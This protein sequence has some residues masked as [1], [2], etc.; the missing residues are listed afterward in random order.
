[1][2]IHFLCFISLVGC[3]IYNEEVNIPTQDFDTIIPLNVET[4][5]K[6]F[7]LEIDPIE[8]DSMYS[9]FNEEIEIEASLNLIKN[10]DFLIKN[11]K[12][13]IQVKGSFSSSFDLKSLGIKFD[14]VFDNS[15]RELIDVEVLPFHTIDKIKSFRLRNSG[16][17][18][19]LTMLKDMSL[20]KLALY[21]KLDVDVMYSEQAVVFINDTFLGIMNIR[22]E[23]N[24]HG[25][26]RL[27]GAKKENVTLVNIKARG[28][29][30]K[31]D[32]DFERI[33]RLFEAIENSEID[34]LLDEIDIP[35]F[36][37][38]II[39]ETYIGNIDWPL[40]NVRIFAIDEEPFR[41]VLF[42][43]DMAAVQ[44]TNAPPLSFLSEPINN[45]GVNYIST[46]FDLLYE[47]EDFK[48]DF[49]SR[50]EE[51]VSSSIL[52]SSSFE[53]I[54][55]SYKDNI[56]HIMPTQIDR[57]SFP[58]SLTEWIIEVDRLKYNF[59]KRELSAKRFIDSD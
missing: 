3:S 24:G 48:T 33:D 30:E 53:L 6:V 12:V 58:K 21:A 20:V 55:D 35:N 19:K 34:L 1:M 17:D 18:F 43:L 32:G 49:N 42:D 13:E 38:Y 10:G 37:D 9:N 11:E 16:N 26:S 45:D 2:G 29:V 46:L 22:T 8:F 50:F 25:L 23:T 57:Y 40:N 14:K 51:I 4:N 54:V 28:V 15:N 7:N 36:I 47:N 41:F 52:A 31:K 56:K 27:Y 39:Y 44:K 5:L 59:S